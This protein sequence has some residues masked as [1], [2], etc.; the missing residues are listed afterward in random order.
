MT[1]ITIASWM[2][3]VVGV[4]ILVPSFI[5]MIRASAHLMETDDKITFCSIAGTVAGSVI[6]CIG[7]VPYLQYL[8][9]ITIIP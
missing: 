1:C 9:C 5:M 7:V 4:V 3:A 6:F 8:P 2:L